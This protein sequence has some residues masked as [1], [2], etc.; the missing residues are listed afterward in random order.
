MENSLLK[1]LQLKSGHQ[2]LIWNAP[3]N[4]TDVLG[5]LP[6]DVAF[7]FDSDQPFNAL[8]IFVLNKMELWAALQAK[9]QV[10]EPQT[11]CWILYPKAK[12]KLAS[13][14]NLMQSWGE[15]KNYNLTPCASAAIDE[16]WTALRIKPIDSTKRSGMGNAEIQTNAYGEY[17]DVA[18]KI[19]KLPPDLQ[20][21]L[22]QDTNALGFYEQLSYSNRKEYVLWVLSAKQEKTRLDRIQKTLEKLIA[23][24]KNPTEK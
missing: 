22:E 16:T 13:D 24:K 4:L 23:G 10:I 11:I 6:D 3:A 7:S 8:L 18:N 14:L 9:H 5:T 17:V 15:L 21:I 1:K 2:V 12:T 19:V 20:A